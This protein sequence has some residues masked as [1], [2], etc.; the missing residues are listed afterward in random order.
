MVLLRMHHL[1]TNLHHICC[2][3]RVK[4]Q[5]STCRDVVVECSCPLHKHKFLFSKHLAEVYVYLL[6]HFTRAGCFKCDTLKVSEYALEFI[7]LE[8]ASQL[9]ASSVSIPIPF[10]IFICQANVQHWL[11]WWWRQRGALLDYI[12]NQLLKKSWICGY[13]SS[14]P[15]IYLYYD[16][17]CLHLLWSGALKILLLPF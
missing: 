16:I 14:Y 12:K 6:F 3:V 7:N 10:G 8:Q 15:T 9:F 11:D 2:I 1:R 13:T 5:N 4:W 17:R